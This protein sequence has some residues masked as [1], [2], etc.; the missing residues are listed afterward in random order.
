MVARGL[1]PSV[2]V[3]PSPTYTHSGTVTTPS[4]SGYYRGTSTPSPNFSGIGSALGTAW[5][6]SGI[7]ED[8]MISNGYTKSQGNGG[9]VQCDLGYG[10]I[11]EE[12]AQKCRVRRNEGVACKY[13]TDGG[14]EPSPADRQSCLNRGGVIVRD[15]TGPDTSEYVQCNLGQGIIIETDR[16]SCSAQGVEILP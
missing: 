12:T 11:I 3:P 1:A 4:G 10:V 16:A 7:I 15:Y 13:P 14:L 9:L 6:R 2:Y 8:C 5:A